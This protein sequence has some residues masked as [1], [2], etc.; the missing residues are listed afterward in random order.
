MSASRRRPSALPITR[1]PKRLL[2]HEC[3]LGVYGQPSGKS[4]SRLLAD[5]VLL[6]CNCSGAFALPI[7][8]ALEGIVSSPAPLFSWAD[9]RLAGDHPPASS[10]SVRSSLVG[11]LANSFF[12]TLFLRTLSFGTGRLGTSSLECALPITG[13]ISEGECLPENPRRR[14]SDRARVTPR[15]RAPVSTSEGCRR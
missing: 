14:R 7:L 12:G 10:G 11:P 9:E 8:I 15:W 5:T 4:R 6:Y 1:R 2:I 13:G 3:S